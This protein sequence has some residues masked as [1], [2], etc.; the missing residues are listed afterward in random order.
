MPENPFVGEPCVHWSELASLSAASSDHGFKR[1]EL[2]LFSQESKHVHVNG[3]I[4]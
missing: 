1:L 4:T 3:S 2:F